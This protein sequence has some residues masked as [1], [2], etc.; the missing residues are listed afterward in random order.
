SHT[1]IGWNVSPWY[2]PRQVSSRRLAGRPR[3]RWYWRHILIATSTLTEPESHRNT[4]SRPVSATRRVHS[5]TAGSWVRP[6]NITWLIRPTWSRT[7]ASRTGWR[8]PWIAAHLELIPST[9]S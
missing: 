4:W 6:P 5:R 7:A 1:L 8:Y 3:D 9:S 2:P